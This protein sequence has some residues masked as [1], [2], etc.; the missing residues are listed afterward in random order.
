MG[1]AAKT[2]ASI[3]NL[4]IPIQHVACEELG[5]LAQLF[6]SVVY[7][8]LLMDYSPSATSERSLYIRAKK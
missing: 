4:D 5:K 8:I 3:I 7:P 1:S 2:M 6:L